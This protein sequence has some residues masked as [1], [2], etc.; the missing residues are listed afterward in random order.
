[1][2]FTTGM[3]P[4]CRDQILVQTFSAM[5]VKDGAMLAYLCA[6]RARSARPASR[7]NKQVTSVAAQHY[8]VLRV[9]VVYR[10]HTKLPA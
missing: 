3:A 5:L 6:S 9:S 1:M 4:M 10:S 7:T 2:P 8:A